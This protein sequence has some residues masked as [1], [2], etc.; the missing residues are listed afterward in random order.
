[1]WVSDLLT[2][3][4]RDPNLRAVLVDAVTDPYRLAVLDDGDVADVQRGLHR[5]AAA[6]PAGTLLVGLDVL[7]DEVDA[8]DDDALAARVDAQYLARR[9]LVLAGE[10]D[11]LV[12]LADLHQSTSGASEMMR[13]NFFSRSSRPTGPKMRV[14]RGSPPS[15]MST[16][17]FSSKRM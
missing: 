6:L 11:H 17:A 10:D 7:R 9:A 1:S 14:P 2:A 12:A 15:R 5:D 13:M 4:A 16:A 8:L 3:T